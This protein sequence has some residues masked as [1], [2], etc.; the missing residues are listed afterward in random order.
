[1]GPGQ[2]FLTWVGSGQLS[3]VRVLIWKIFPRK[4][5]IFQFNPSRVKKIS[6]GQVKKYSG[7]RQVS[8]LFTAGQKYAQVVSGQGPSLLMTDAG[9]HQNQDWGVTTES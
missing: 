8:L 4:S 6:S 1:M 2:Y 7:Q 5:Q 9:G 3:L